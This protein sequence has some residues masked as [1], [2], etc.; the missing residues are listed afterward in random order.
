MALLSLVLLGALAGSA[1]A[2][3]RPN[4]VLIMADDM[5]YECVAANGGES[6][7]TPHLDRLAEQGMRFEHCYAQP[8][9]TPSRVKIMTGM[10]NSR[11]YTRFG[12]LD[13]EAYTFG[14]LLREAGYATCVVG[15]WQ[16]EGGFDA[17]HR[18]GFDEY[19]L[20]QLTRRPNRY[21][22]PGLEINGEEKDFKD[23]EY[24]PDIVAEYACDFI[25]RHA[26]GDEPFFVYYPMILPHWPFE[27]TPD[28]E[29]WDPT[30]RRGDDSEKS[31]KGWREWGDRFF[32][33]MVRY[34]DKLV[35]RIVSKLEEQGV[36]EDTLVIF[37]GDNG[38]A[39]SVTSVLNGRE[40][41]GGKGKMTDAG[42]RVPMI[43]SWPGTTPAGRVDADLVDFSDYFPTLAEVAGAEM[44][45][46]LNVDGRSFAGELRGRETNRR[47]WI[48]CWYFRDGKVNPDS[49]WDNGEFARTRRYKLYKD[50]RFYNISEDVQ[51]QDPL[52]D[53]ELTPEARRVRRELRRVIEQNTRPDFYEPNQQQGDS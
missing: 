28:S 23:G 8:I 52:K 4:I 16:L 18:F 1:D 46:G 47:E 35:G 2:A 42:M 44:P 20:W 50:G 26:D 53:D 27:P 36:R 32:P 14:N 15:K 45:E 10:H 21:P 3:E 5:G 41:E 38:T 29:E 30:F 24:G 7:E 17:P 13:E 25:E 51:E 43:A 9:C 33:D 19:C 40:V 22:N 11:N 34:T 48:Y 49:K 31:R 6:Y 37:T 12:H 39:Q